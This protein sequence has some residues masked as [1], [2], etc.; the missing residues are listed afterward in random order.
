MVEENI[1]E[2]CKHCRISI[3]SDVVFTEMETICDKTMESFPIKE[4]CEHFENEVVK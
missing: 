3:S 1:C 2:K 4:Q